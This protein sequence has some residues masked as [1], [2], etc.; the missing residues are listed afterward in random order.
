MI[1]RGKRLKKP[2][3]QIYPRVE[4]F[5]KIR[6]IVAESGNEQT[7]MLL[8]FIDIQ[9]AHAKHKNEYSQEWHQKQKEEKNLLNDVICSCLTLQFQD[10]ETIFKKIKD[11]YPEKEITLAMINSRLGRMVKEGRIDCRRVPSGKE[12]NFIKLYALPLAETQ[13]LEEDTNINIDPYYID[14]NRTF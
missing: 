8:D 6:N 9:I 10:I 1:E 4:T 14:P 11:S 3:K 7:D 12:R 5:Q 13:N 2:K